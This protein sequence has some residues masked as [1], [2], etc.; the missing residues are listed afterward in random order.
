MQV[1]ARLSVYTYDPKLLDDHK[2]KYYLITILSIPRGIEFSC[3]LLSKKWY[4]KKR[5]TFKKIMWLKHRRYKFTCINSIK[6]MDRK[7]DREKIECWIKDKN[8]IKLYKYIYNE[9][10][11]TRGK[12]I[13]SEL[14]EA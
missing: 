11:L 2:F 12:M 8:S 7:G 6:V 13:Y 10:R 14:H 5:L 3:S 4:V 1:L 9:F